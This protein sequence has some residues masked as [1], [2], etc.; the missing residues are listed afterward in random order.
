MSKTTKGWWNKIIQADFDKDGDMDYI[1]GNLGLNYKYKA[2][3]KEPLH[4]YWD[5]FDQNAR[6]LM[7][8]C[9]VLQKTG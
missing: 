6:R 2:S 9:Q 7:K 8:R 5:D 3:V 1:A 4:L